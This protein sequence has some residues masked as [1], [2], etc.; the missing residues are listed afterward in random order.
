MS[1][2]SKRIWGLDLIRA[3]AA[4]SVVL[5][6]MIV[7]FRDT[8][9]IKGMNNIF[10][11]LYGVE[12]FFVLSGF[13]IGGIILRNFEKISDLKSEKGRAKTVFSFWYRRW[14]RTLPAYY[15]YLLIYILIAPGAAENA[16]LFQYTFF[17]Q[18]FAFDLRP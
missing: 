10:G 2:L 6:H 15:I 8:A 12:I 11:G 7:H 9:I 16:N 18:N 13:L 14:M 1:T 4:L 5:S 3:V 17:L